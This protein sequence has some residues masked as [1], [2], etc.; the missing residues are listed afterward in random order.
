VYICICYGITDTRIKQ[1]IHSGCQ[2]C[3]DLM[4]CLNVGTRCRRCH[5]DLQELLEAHVPAN[6]CPGASYLVPATGV[7]EDG[8]PF[9]I[10]SHHNHRNAL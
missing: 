5:S 7:Q 1:A 2:S 6:A 9:P 10:E 3:A 8:L 4:N